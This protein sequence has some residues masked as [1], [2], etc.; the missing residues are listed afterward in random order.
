MIEHVKI[1]NDFK[2]RPY[3]VLDNDKDRA[4]LVAAINKS[5]KLLRRDHSRKKE[6]EKRWW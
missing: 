4:K 6:S 3:E 2:E 5:I 1:L